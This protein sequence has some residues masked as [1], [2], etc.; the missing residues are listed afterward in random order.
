[1]IPD[2][3]TELRTAVEERIA[4]CEPFSRATVMVSVFDHRP[5]TLRHLRVYRDRAGELYL[6]QGFYS[7]RRKYLKDMAGGSILTID[8]KRPPGMPIVSFYE[9]ELTL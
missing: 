8:G 9:L 4:A 6:I 1:M 7:K 3:Y 2:K 5:H